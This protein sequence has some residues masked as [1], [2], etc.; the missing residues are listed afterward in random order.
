[1]G[2]RPGQDLAGYLVSYPEEMA[3]SDDDPAEVLDRYHTPDL[4]W[5]NDGMLMDRPR[6]I[7]HARPV[8]KNARSVRIE[9]HD[10]VADGDRVAARFTVHAQMRKGAPLTIDVHFF[11]RLAPD[12]RLCHI[13]Q[14][15]RTNRASAE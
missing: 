12:G 9:V 2:P 11:G 14:I 4:E 7:A 5:V 6:L 10:T 15:T 3:F 8:R 13:D 1:M